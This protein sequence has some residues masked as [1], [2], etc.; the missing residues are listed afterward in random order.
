MW[1][2]SS[3]KAAK[4]PTNIA[5][6]N[7]DG[8]HL[9]HQQVMA[10][11]LG[12][13]LGTWPILAGVEGSTASTN[14]LPTADVDTTS[15]RLTNQSVLSLHQG[16]LAAGYSHLPE[17]SSTG[18]ESSIELPIGPAL[19]ESGAYSTVVTFS[20]HPHEYFSRQARPLLTPVAE[21][22]WQLARLGMHQLVMLPFNQALAELSPQDFIENVLIQGL[23]AQQISVGSDFHFGKGRSGNAETLMT[24]AAKH[25]V[26][27]VQVP[28]K[29]EEGDRISSSRIRT[30]LQ[31]G[32]PET[33]AQLLGRPY[34]L[35]GRV[36]QGQQLGRTIGFPTANLQIPRK[37]Y[38]PCTG[39]YSVRIYGAEEAVQAAPLQGVMNIGN[40]PTV[41]GQAM[42]VEVHVLNWTG[43]LY[44][45][46]LTV[47]LE[48]FIRPE[49]KFDSLAALKEQIERDCGVA[50]AHLTHS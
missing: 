20:P 37:K 43:D 32:H 19:P 23:N 30:A 38:L 7:F 16:M 41:N 18:T 17:N 48:S 12:G 34:I 45:K 47:S 25:N 42:T 40:R 50:I 9:G 3:L 5:L 11:I 6:G 27:V 15:S 24:I 26:P 2:T 22:I 14:N 39:V 35:T 1:I 31:S 33:A 4:A 44:G 36:V 49:Q 10:P 28:L 21:K 29:H 13:R 46:M 8:V